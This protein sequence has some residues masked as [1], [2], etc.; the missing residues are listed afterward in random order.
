MYCVKYTTDEIRTKTKEGTMKQEINELV[1]WLNNNYC[2]SEIDYKYILKQGKKYFKINQKDQKGISESV[3]A[4]IDQE[5]NILK[6]NS[7]KSPHKTPRG[8]IYKK[9]DW[10]NVCYKYGVKYINGFANY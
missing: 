6:P 10:S 2:K 5:G 4:F 8:S 1:N 3:Y 9:E 7:Y